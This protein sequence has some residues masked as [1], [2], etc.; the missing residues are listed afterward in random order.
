MEEFGEPYQY[1]QHYPVGVADGTTLKIQASGTLEAAPYNPSC[2]TLNGGKLG[3]VSGQFAPLNSLV[4][5][6]ATL[7]N[8]GAAP[9]GLLLD[10]D[11]EVG[12]LSDLEENSRTVST[13]HSNVVKLLYPI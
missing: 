11:V 2:M 8:T 1:T 13:L 4:L 3:N 10:N 12:I 9:Q 7:K 6:G 5:N